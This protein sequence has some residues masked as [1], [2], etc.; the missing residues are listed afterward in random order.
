[1]TRQDT[2]KISAIKIM[3]KT[4]PLFIT[5]MIFVIAISI[6]V[7]SVGNNYYGSEPNRRDIFDVRSTN[8]GFLVPNV[9]LI[10]K[11]LTKIY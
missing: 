10:G 7:Q 9:L 4:R 11:I 2:N 1:M 3:K 6:P 8:K 5:A